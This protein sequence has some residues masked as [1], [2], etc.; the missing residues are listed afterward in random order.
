MCVCVC[1]CVCVHRQDNVE[2]ALRALS[3]LTSLDLSHT[4][5]HPRTSGLDAV[6][7]TGAHTHTHNAASRHS[8]CYSLDVIAFVRAA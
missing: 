3:G 4:V 5:I 2:S 6:I 7:R 8:V 1:L